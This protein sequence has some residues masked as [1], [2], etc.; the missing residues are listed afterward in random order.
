MDRT[1]RN[2]NYE[3][4]DVFIVHARPEPN[5]NESSSTLLNGQW[6]VQ[7]IGEA[8][9]VV[10]VKILCRLSVAKQMIGYYK[11]KERLEVDF[12]GDMYSGVI[13]SKPTSDIAEL[14]ETDPKYIMTFDLAV[15]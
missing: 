6:V 1:I 2:S 14:D 12:L 8:S 11:T 9:E 5:L 3:D 13:I 7:T 4:I 10:K 15:M